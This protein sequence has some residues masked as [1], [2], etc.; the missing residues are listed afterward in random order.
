MSG[1]PSRVFSAATWYRSTMSAQAFGVLGVGTDP[2]PDSTLPR[3]S[4]VILLVSASMLARS[5]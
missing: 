5:A 4:V 1:M 3:F 2:P